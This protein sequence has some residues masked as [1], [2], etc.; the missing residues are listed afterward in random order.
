MTNSPNYITPQGL[1]NLRDEL[2]KLLY[3]E[4]PVVVKTVTWAASLGDRSEN[5]DYQY[6]KRRL[7][8]I[9]RRIHVLQKRIETAQAVD[10]RQQTTDQIKFGA[11]VILE[12][13]KERRV[14]Y[15]I[16]GQD[17]TDPQS[18]KISWDS[19]V[20]KSLMHKR[21]GDQVVVRRPKGE[22]EFEVVGIKY[23]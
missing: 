23:M 5:A 13:E 4:R 22:I 3:G 15:Q 11:I 18:G 19:P 21:V 2:K 17:E 6:G 14:S 20:A 9:D 8:E 16:V 1:Q 10:P 7:R 12:D